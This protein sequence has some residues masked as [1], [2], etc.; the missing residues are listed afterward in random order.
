MISNDL[1]LIDLHRHLEG[2]IRLATILELAQQFNIVLPA[3]TVAELRPFVQITEIQPGVLAFLEKFNLPMQVM[4]DL[5][6]VRRI[7]YEAVLDAA[8]EGIDYLELRFSPLFISQNHHF[9]PEEV[10]ETV[11][12]GVEAGQKDRDIKVNL[13]GILSRTYGP[14]LA[15]KELDAL[16]PYAGKIVGLD[17]AGDE[18]NYPAELFEDHFDHAI[19]T[20]LKITVHAGESA[21]PE[22]IW[23]SIRLLGA[24]RIG[25]GLAAIQDP[26]LMDFLFERQIGIEANLTS[27][28]QTSSVADYA[29]HPLR[30]FLENGLLASINSDDPGISGIDLKY[31][32]EV[33]AP[34]AG[35]SP[36]MI[37][38]A[39]LNALESAFLK[40]REKNELLKKKQSKDQ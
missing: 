38:Q 3:N 24:Q 1:P 33:A 17:L 4:G 31:E 8:A 16:L 19:E 15:R 34:K 20:G 12:D 37:R 32:Y 9:K 35:L 40:P 13:L 6:A 30:H 23:K 27:N 18:A 21:G 11:I 28:V 29:S 36:Q 5:D 2:N 26:K 7:A 22:S 10:V 25:H 39:Q 14:Q